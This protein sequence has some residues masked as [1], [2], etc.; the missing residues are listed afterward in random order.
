MAHGVC[1][2]WI[3]YLLANPLRRMLNNPRNIV[4]P[5]VREGM[6]VFEPGPGMG[7]FTLE[8]AGLVGSSGKVVAVDVQQ[9]ML[10]SLERRARRKGLD[11]RIE[12]RLAQPSTMGID[13]L[14]GS[15]DFVLA[16]AMVHELPDA[17]KFFQESFAALR[18]GG[19]LLFA[20]PANHVEEK[21]FQVSLGLARKAGFEEE[22]SPAIRSHR[23]RLLVK[24][25]HKERG[26]RSQ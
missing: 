13:D 10:N 11:G 19:G 25:P 8:M 1:P 23:S 20:E 7:F 5:F 12:L 22:N 4:S 14:K 21:E 26:E 9:K 2:W 18:Q 6:T 3:G 17:G 15:V 16:I 24:P